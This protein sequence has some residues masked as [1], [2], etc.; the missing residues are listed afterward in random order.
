MM[1]MEQEIVEFYCGFLI[2]KLER[3][4]NRQLIKRFDKTLRKQ[5]KTKY[6]HSKEINTFIVAHAH[7]DATHY[8]DSE[9]RKRLEAKLTDAYNKKYLSKIKMN[10]RRALKKDIELNESKK[11]LL[12]AIRH[13]PEAQAVEMEEQIETRFKELL[14]DLNRRFDEMNYKTCFTLWDLPGVEEDRLVLYNR[15][16]KRPSSIEGEHEAIGE[17][18]DELALIIFSNQFLP[19]LKTLLQ[20]PFELAESGVQILSAHRSILTDPAFNDLHKADLTN[21]L[22]VLQGKILGL[23]DIIKVS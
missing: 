3:L 4:R 10:R 23:R 21:A 11:A 7:L 16:I 1:M 22:R 6:A 12:R 13:L 8:E 5:G 18:V 14:A 2:N 9:N 17:L 20:G 19:N 15:I